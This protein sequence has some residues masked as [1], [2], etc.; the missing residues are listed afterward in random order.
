MSCYSGTLLIPDVFTPSDAV[1]SMDLPYGNVH[2]HAVHEIH[3]QFSSLGRHRIYRT[4]AAAYPRAA[5]PCFWDSPTSRHTHREK[6]PLATSSIL[7]TKPP[8][9]SSNTNNLPPLPDVRTHLD[10]YAQ[11]L[12]YMYHISGSVNKSIQVHH[13]NKTQT[14]FFFF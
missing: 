9:Y 13:K 4:C 11:T 3:D 10:T 12:T 5:H 2:L 1:G 6:A 14:F 7:Q 8:N